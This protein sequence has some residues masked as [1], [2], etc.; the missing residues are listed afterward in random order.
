MLFISDILKAVSRESEVRMFAD[1]CALYRKIKN[2]ED[3]KML[4]ND[5]D[6]LQKWKA[7]WL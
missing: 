7:D 2:T 3:A 6:K 1:D 5:L 4:Q